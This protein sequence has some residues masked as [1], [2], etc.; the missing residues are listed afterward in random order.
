MGRQLNRVS[1]W[2][3]VVLAVSLLWGC[4]SDRDDLNA[5]IARIKSNPGSK[6]DDIPDIPP[7][8]K[9]EY[10]S[11]HLKDPFERYATGAEP[12]GP[13]LDPEKDMT[14]CPDPTR[15]KQI[16]EDYA[17]DSLRMVGV[18]AQDGV[19]YALVRS[20][21]GTVHRVKSGDYVGLNHGQIKAIGE[22]RIE[23]DEI[24][25]NQRGCELR[26][27]AMMLEGLK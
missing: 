1:K 20:P 13:V 22:T 12:T 18:M 25:S 17:L 11:A 14:N 15:P 23:I 9:H 4:G 6:I 27:A 3:L 10:A 7:Y 5:Y 26:S 19:T 8:I 2:A 16:L 24:L 21:E